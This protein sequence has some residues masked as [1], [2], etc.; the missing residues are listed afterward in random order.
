MGQKAA[1][2]CIV[3]ASPGRESRLGG[4]TNWRFRVQHFSY[5]RVFN[6]ESGESRFE[7][8]STTLEPTDFAP[9]APPLNLAPLG[10]A[11]AIALV[12]GDR[13]WGGDIPHPSPARQIMCTLAGRF[14]ATTSNGESR[15]LEP[16]DLL[17][18][19]DIAGKGHSTR[20]LEDGTIVAAIRLAGGEGLGPEADSRRS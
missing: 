15:E 2:V 16:G 7:D 20:I 5:I 18:V 17:L 8:V 1:P 13:D 11:E 4:Q 6:D 10:Q 9:P 12:G 14:Q 19:E 3:E